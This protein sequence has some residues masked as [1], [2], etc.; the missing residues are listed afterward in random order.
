MEKYVDYSYYIDTYRGNMPEIDF[1]KLAVIATAKIKAHTFNRIGAEVPDEVK[2]CACV[3]AEKIADIQK[4]EGKAS[5]SVGVW[6]VSFRDAR[7]SNEIIVDTIKAL[8][9]DVKLNGV[10]IL[11]RG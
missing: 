3:L 1:N 4:T 6:S 9:G 5:E 8:L 7:N 10:P 11:Y 2:W